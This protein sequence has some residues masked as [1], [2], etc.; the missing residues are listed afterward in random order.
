MEIPFEK[1]SSDNEKILQRLT[2]V[3]ALDDYEKEYT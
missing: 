1:I 2:K 3:G